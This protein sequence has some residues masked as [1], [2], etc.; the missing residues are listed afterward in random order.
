MH[1]E[2]L[3]NLYSLPSIFKIVKSRMRWAGHIAPMRV[4]MSAYRIFLEKE[5]ATMKSKT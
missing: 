2:E 4:K 1:N 5:E 3:H